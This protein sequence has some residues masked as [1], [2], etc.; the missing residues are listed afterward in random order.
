MPSLQSQL[1]IVETSNLRSYPPPNIT[2]TRGTDVIFRR[3]A[4]GAA[5]NRI[6]VSDVLSAPFHVTI[7]NRYSR[8]DGWRVG[9]KA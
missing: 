2:I 7:C 3:E 8:G 6:M 5:Q 9:T 1:L 4:F